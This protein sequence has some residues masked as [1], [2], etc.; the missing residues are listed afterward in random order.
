MGTNDKSLRILILEDVAE[1]AELIE[2][3]VRQANIGFISRRAASRETFLSAL[4]DFQPDLILSDYRLPSFDG[5]SALAI[6]RKVCPGV[7]FILVSGAIGEDMAIEVIKSGATDYVLKNRLSRL[8][9][10]CGVRSGRLRIAKSG[11]GLKNRSA[12]AKN[13]IGTSWRR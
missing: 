4:Q 11:S 6:S 12:R 1:D 13:A 9:H 8:A 2:R 10:R 3:E 5:L 7:P